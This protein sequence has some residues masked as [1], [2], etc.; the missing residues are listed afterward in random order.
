MVDIHQKPETLHF[1]LSRPEPDSNPNYYKT[2][3]GGNGQTVNVVWQN[4]QQNIV[5]MAQTAQAIA[6]IANQSPFT[7]AQ[8]ALQLIEGVEKVRF[9]NGE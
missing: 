3:R 7:P 1:G 4:Q 6:T 2:V 5:D 9:L 8:L